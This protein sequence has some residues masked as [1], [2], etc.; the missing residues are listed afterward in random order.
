MGFGD[1]FQGI[2][3]HPYLG[4][5]EEGALGFGKGIGRAIGGFYCH[6]MAGECCLQVCG[7]D[8]D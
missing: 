5:K 1:A 7:I 6:L 4:A 3:R 2:I 8:I